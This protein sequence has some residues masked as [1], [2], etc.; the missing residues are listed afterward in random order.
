MI[1]I[2]P[3]SRGRFMHA[4]HNTDFN[5]EPHTG[6]TVLDNQS[7]PVVGSWEDYTGSAKV[8]KSIKMAA[9][10]EDEFQGTDAGVEG[11]RF[12]PLNAVGE[13]RST[14]RLRQKINYLEF[15][16]TDCKK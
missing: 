1:R 14:H 8:A 12:S 13:T 5:F 16:M 7:V 4:K 2:D 10:T 3:S 9:G 15:P 11:Q 6:D